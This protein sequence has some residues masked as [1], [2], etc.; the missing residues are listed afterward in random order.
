MLSIAQSAG[1][2]FP[3]A[4]YV[5]R[6]QS[7]SFKSLVKECDGSSIVLQVDFS[8][9]AT[10]ASQREIHAISSL[11]S[12]PGDPFHSSCVDKACMMDQT[13]AAWSLS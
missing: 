3:A 7:A 1:L 9:N 8:K 13:L 2:S 12:W 11:E 5:K 4:H 6:K 10:I